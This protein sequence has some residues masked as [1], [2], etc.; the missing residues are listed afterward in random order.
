[1]KGWHVEPLA[2]GLETQLEDFDTWPSDLAIDFL[3]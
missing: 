3:Q 2:C 1:M